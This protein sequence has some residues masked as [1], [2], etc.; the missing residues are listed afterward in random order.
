MLVPNAARF[1]LA[2]KPALGHQALLQLVERWQLHDG[3]LPELE[4][5][6]PTEQSHEPTL[7]VQTPTRK[8]ISPDP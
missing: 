3:K 6:P 4:V 2:D 8:R 7:A 1:E 5:R